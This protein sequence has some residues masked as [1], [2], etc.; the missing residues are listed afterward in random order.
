MGEE[1]GWRKRS[2]LWLHRRL[3]DLGLL[4]HPWR[5]KEGEMRQD[6]EDRRVVTIENPD[7]LSFDSPKHVR[8]DRGDLAT[9]RTDDVVF[10]SPGRIVL[11]GT[12]EITIEDATEV[13]IEDPAGFPD[14]TSTDDTPE[15]VFSDCGRIVVRHPTTATFH[16]PGEFEPLSVS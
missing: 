16:E 2:V 13:V 10:E 5:G 14:S 8:I 11:R 6:R 3:V 1:Y 4:H 7:R 12:M 9:E 15:R